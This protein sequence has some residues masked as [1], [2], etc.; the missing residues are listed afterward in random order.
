MLSRRSAGGDTNR[1][2]DRIERGVDMRHRVQIGF[3]R[4]EQFVLQLRVKVL[5]QRAAQFRLDLVV[6]LACRA[7]EESIEHLLRA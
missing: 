7:S 5:G 4:A 3:E 6:G 2:R 1:L